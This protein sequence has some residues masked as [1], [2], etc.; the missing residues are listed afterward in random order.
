MARQ[1]RRSLSSNLSEAERSEQHSMYEDASGPYPV[2]IESTANQPALLSIAEAPMTSSKYG[3]GSGSKLTSDIPSS[4]TL[5]SDTPYVDSRSFD[6]T[7]VDRGCSDSDHSD[8]APTDGHTSYVHSSNG[9]LTEAFLVEESPVNKQLSNT[10]QM[11]N[12]REGTPIEYK[13]TE[14]TEVGK[15]H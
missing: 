10:L 4:D 8:K 6:S 7:T 3:E 12:C 9:D 2:E 1:R 11:D 13:T 14:G 15:G 5:Y